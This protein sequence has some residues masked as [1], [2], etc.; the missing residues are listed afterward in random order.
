MFEK[1]SYSSSEQAQI[2]KILKDNNVTLNYES[3]ED[4]SNSLNEIL[5]ISLEAYKRNFVKYSYNSLFF[6]HNLQNKKITGYNKIY[7]YYNLLMFDLK[8]ANMVEQIMD[9]LN[10]NFATCGVNV[11]EWF[12]IGYNL[13]NLKTKY[14][15]STF[16]PMHDINVA[17]DPDTNNLVVDNIFAQLNYQELLFHKNIRLKSKYCLLSRLTYNISFSLSEVCYVVSPQ[18]FMEEF[19]VEK[20]KNYKGFYNFLQ[21]KIDIF[22][23]LDVSFKVGDTNYISLEFPTDDIICLDDVLSCG[24]ITEEQKNYIQN[25]SKTKEANNNFMIKMEWKNSENVNVLWYNAEK[26]IDKKF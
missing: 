2:F 3:S 6:E 7:C 4:L 5:I 26:T 19:V 1:Y 14:C 9:A 15:F 10:A 21:D 8:F 22:D 20:Y 25:S 16:C 18:I 13:D 23:G 24:I 12:Y 17:Y 11:M